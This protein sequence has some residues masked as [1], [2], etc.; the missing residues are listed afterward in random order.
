M[1]P[2]HAASIF[3]HKPSLWLGL[4]ACEALSKIR[5][6][7]R[8]WA[9]D[10]VTSDFILPGILIPSIHESKRAHADLVC[11]EPRFP[12]PITSH[13]LPVG[14]WRW[15][16]HYRHHAALPPVKRLGNNIEHPSIHPSFTRGKASR[17]RNF[18]LSRAGHRR[19]TVS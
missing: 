15:R 18:R 5:T 11:H 14:C 1:I 8:V 2:N 17:A 3:L 10:D 12:L 4:L 19:Q 16:W 13:H 7:A 9:A 6:R